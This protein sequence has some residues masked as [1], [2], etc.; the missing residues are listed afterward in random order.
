MD[1][2]TSSEISNNE[3]KQIKRQLGAPTQI[4][5]QQAN[6]IS[7]QRTSNTLKNTEETKHTK[8]TTE[9]QRNEQHNCKSNRRNQNQGTSHK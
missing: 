2:H 4:N 5:Q 9:N 6:M 8:S 3:T 7:K 1:T